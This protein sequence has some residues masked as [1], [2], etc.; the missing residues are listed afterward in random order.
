MDRDHHDGC[1]HE[2]GDH[3]GQGRALHAEARK[4]EVSENQQIVEDQVRQDR[5]DPRLHGEHGLAALAHR[6]GVDVGDHE[7]QVADQHDPEIGEA[8]LQ[9][10]LQIA[11]SFSVGEVKRDELPREKQE[12]RREAEQHEGADKELDAEGL[13]HAGIVF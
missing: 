3:R 7:G 4:A 13:A 8:V 10:L 6:A 1:F 5:R 11:R 12:H 9:R 2:S